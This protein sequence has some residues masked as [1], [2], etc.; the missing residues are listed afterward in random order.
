MP[1]IETLLVNEIRKFGD[2][3]FSAFDKFPVDTLAVANAWG[4]AVDIYAKAVIPA[5][6]AV[7]AKEAFIAVM[8]PA[9]APGAWLIAFPLACTAYAVALGAGMLPAFVA[10]PPPAPLV[11][12]SA[13]ALGLAKGSGED[14]AKEMANLINLWMKTGTAT[15]SGGGPPVPWS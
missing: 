4:E 1:L 6:T 3:E 13:I 9:S 10:V 5:S 12:A 15:P 14:W 2:P 11:I 7:G 8:V